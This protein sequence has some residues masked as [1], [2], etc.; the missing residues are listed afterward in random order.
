MRSINCILI[1]AFVVF[2]ACAPPASD[3]S[4][5]GNSSA[6]T[7][8]GASAQPSETPRPAPAEESGELKGDF[9][10]TA[11]IVDKKYEIKEPAILTGV[12]TGRHEGFDRI[13]FEFRGAEMPGYH[14]EYIDKPVRA[15]GSGEV[16]PL[17]GDAWLQIRFEPTNAHT[18]D[19]KSTLSFRELVPKHPVVLE[20]KS[21]CDFEAQ[22]EW[23]A[24]TSR[25]NKYRVIELTNPTR[26][27]VDIKHK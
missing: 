19:G 17:A 13:V 7:P 12:R 4:D 15:C 23:V 5:G 9:D 26:L 27:V 2:L 11:G 8:A 20:L 18:E 24:G 14:V 21:T 16:V 25:P 6:V 10:G 22:V 1:A 3:R